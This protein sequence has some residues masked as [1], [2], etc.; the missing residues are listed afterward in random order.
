MGELLRYWTQN[1]AQEDFI[2]LTQLF[3]QW[4][5]QRGHKIEE[6]IP[7]L[8]SVAASI[9]N[10]QGNRTLSQLNAPSEDILYIHWHYH[11]TDIKKNTIRE[12]YN[13]TLKS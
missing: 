1:T 6:I 10:I 11:L 13:A 7:T 4:L 3:I 9:D 5:I 8:E 12:A 2:H